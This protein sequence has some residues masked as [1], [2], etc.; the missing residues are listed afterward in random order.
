LSNSRRV[1]PSSATWAAYITSS[2]SEKWRTSD[3]SCVTKMTAKPSCLAALICTISERWPTTSR[4][5]VG[6]P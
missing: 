1:R 2:R 3:M 5:E 6:R 4:A